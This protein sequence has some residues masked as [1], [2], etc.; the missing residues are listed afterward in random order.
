MLRSG[1]SLISLVPDWV[2]E[3][4]AIAM[5]AVTESQCAPEDCKPT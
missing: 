5:E 2:E 3:T 1:G 4:V